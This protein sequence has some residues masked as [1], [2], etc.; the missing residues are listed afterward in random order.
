[1][2]P[3]V[4]APAR[5]G[6]PPTNRRITRR[7]ETK[8]REYDT[9]MPERLRDSDES[10]GDDEDSERA[11]TLPMNM[12]QS[13]F[14]LIAA[15]GSR[16]DFNERFDDSS[17]D[18]DAEGTGDGERHREHEDLSRTTIFQPPSRTE[19]QGRSHRRRVSGRRGLLKSLPSLPR[20]MSK[21]KSAPGKLP[22]HGETLDESED[23]ETGNLARPPAI[24]LTRTVSTDRL[25][26]VMSRMLEAHAEMAS[27]SSFDAPDVTKGSDVDDDDNDAVLLANRMMEIFE[28]D[29]PELVI[30]EYPCWL[31]QSVL[32]Q[33]YLYI[34]EKHICFYAYVPR[35][36]NQVLK[37][38]FLAK[39]G[40]RNP[41]YT[42][43]YFRLKGDVLSYYRDTQNQYFPHGQIDLRYGISASS[44]DKDKDGMSFE[45][46]T[47]HRTYRFR[48]DSEAS[49]QEWVK[50]LQR[51][52]F[53]SHN[54]GNSVKI[55]L[56]IANIMD[57]EEV[58]MTDF[59][60]T[61]KIRVIDNDETWAMDEYFFSF[62]KLGQ[63]A[64]DVLK[65]MVE[66]RGA[67]QRKSHDGSERSDVLKAPA[68]SSQPRGDKTASTAPRLQVSTVK[69]T[70]YPLPP[71]SP[72]GTSPIASPDASRKSSL[73]AFR[74][75]GRRSLDTAG[76]P[77]DARP[78]SRGFSGSSRSRSHS[79]Q[80]GSRTP[81]PLQSPIASSESYLQSSVEDPSF[82]NLGASSL[83]DP[84]A[85][86]LLTD[87]AVFRQS[88][89][90]PRSTD[91]HA[92]NASKSRE[93]HAREQ[94]APLATYSGLSSQHNTQHEQIGDKA[95]PPTPTLQ[96][97]SQ[98]GGSSLQ[99]A[100]AFVDYLDRT[101]QKMSSLLATESMGY[102]EKVHGMWQGKRKHYDDPAA[103]RPD[104]DDGDLEKDSEGKLQMSH[105]RFRAHFALPDA[106]KLQATYYGHL[107]RVLPLYG[108]I[109]LSN[110][111][112]CFR[113]LL[114]GT[115]TKLILP[116]QDVENVH[117]EKGFRLGY[118]GLVVI[119]KGHEEIFFEFNLAV[120]RDDCAVTLLRSLET[121]R[122]LKESGRL[123]EEEEAEEQSALFEHNALKSAREMGNPD[124]EPQ[125]ALRTTG[126]EHVPT[127]LEGPD[128]SIISFKPKESMRI[129]CLTIGSRGDVQPY[130]AL[131]KGLIA[132]GHKVKIATHQEFQ[133]WIESHGIDFAE[134]AGDPG[135]L[136]RLCIEHGTFTLAF[137]REA[138]ATF[139][140]WLDSLLH[141]AWEAC[142]DTD[143]LIESPSAMAGIHIAERLRIPYF[144]A[145]TMPWTRT[146]AYPH[147]FVM[148]ES[149]LGG[150]Y[151]YMTYIMF[152]NLFWKA[153]SYQ[154]NRWRNN[155]L[156]L[157]NTS[158]EKMQPNK[159]PFLYNFSPSV[160]APPLDFSD[161]VRV[162]GYWF[163]DEA[164]GYEPPSDLAEFIRKA[165]ADGKKLVYVGFGSIIVDD[166]PKMTREVIDAVQKADV[167]CILSKGWSE[168]GTGTDGSAPT[169]HREEPEMPS[170]IFVIK[171]AP[172]D[173]LFRQIDAAAHHGGSGT[174]GASLRAG[175]PTIIRPFFGDQNFF[176]GRVEDLGVGIALKK[177]GTN[178]FGRAL[179]EATR[180]ERMIV[181][182]RVLGEQ[183]RAEDG[184]D[185]A[186]QAIYRDL[187]YSKSLVERKAGKNHPVP[188]STSAS[189][190]GDFDDDD[191]ESWT[192]IGADEPDPES[193]TKKLSEGLF[194]DGAVGSQLRSG[195]PA[196]AAR[197]NN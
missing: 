12:N 54:E 75:I 106:E 124:H 162:T 175:I 94:L 169:P 71:Q 190:G 123:Y 180:N 39:T 152:D 187:E 1:M 57:V 139:R 79:R 168:R 103:V 194:L 104:D 49:A 7:A 176:A 82:S 178:A 58:H 150:A 129:T 11:S 125:Q 181:K 97:I 183:I 6:S 167:R 148:P 64:I 127:I 48:A 156:G 101:R 105:E 109:Y 84:S 59:A 63:E 163:L 131:C 62:F 182:A 166:T 128:L 193:V 5:P 56:P 17:S 153:T 61:C 28:F 29:E 142:Q 161:W 96:S 191:E 47:R 44:T 25:P 118:S 85:S 147:A 91:G 8:R 107:F 4:T 60:E 111:Y 31:L 121:T 171:S 185:T 86:Q 89:T 53:R 157:P 141:S 114:P 174:T 122:Y 95:Q 160:V 78:H 165:R 41:R 37:S 149:R 98:M 146:R 158:L 13:I 3:E 144:R 34:T 55:A 30:E 119:I 92:S 170:D 10:S 134:I 69:S 73:D 177:W 100:S 16:V 159:V 120:D 197:D 35:T 164:G 116:L 2:A 52:I 102:V 66:E 138:N 88:P 140:G 110:R 186:I 93:A 36:V 77:R 9:N 99:R 83:E 188:A 51:V 38:G 43:F 133:P 26:P 42:R 15:A 87:S 45:V 21:S 155:T 74:C 33:G 18:E 23:N 20:L 154:V 112:F 90:V 108:K 14:G 135:S 76:A 189:Q 184:V 24:E 81:Q 179:W 67:D 27:R 143:L 50:T 22:P 65:I 117:K 130:I 195:R 137:L 113:S 46:V 151:N 68:P 132:D 192:F 173:W 172:H 72:R 70:L 19:K 32:L 115:R 126:L 145:F 196:D 80:G 136:M 40:K